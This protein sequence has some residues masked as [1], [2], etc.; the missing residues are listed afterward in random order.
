ML[1]CLGVVDNHAVLLQFGTLSIDSFVKRGF[2]MKPRIIPILTWSAAVIAGNAPRSDP[3]ALLWIYLDAE[4]NTNHRQDIR[5]R[6]P[7]VIV[8]ECI[9]IPS[10]AEAS[11]SVINSCEERIYMVSHPAPTWNLI[12]LPVQGILYAPSGVLMKICLANFSKKLT[13]LLKGMLFGVGTNI[14]G[15]FSRLQQAAAIFARD[16]EEEDKSVQT[17]WQLYSTRKRAARKLDGQTQKRRPTMILRQINIGGKRPNLRTVHWN[18]SGD[19]GHPCQISTNVGM[20]FGEHWQGQTPHQTD[21]TKCTTHQIHPIRRWARVRELGKAYFNK[22]L[23]MNVVEP[24]R[25]ASASL[26]VFVQKMDSS[27]LTCIDYRTLNNLIIND[28]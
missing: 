16:M 23:R 1:V 26:I 25:S 11:A 9:W 14:L 6:T 24:A 12:V 27:L 8:K 10:N 4:T 19:I 22:M 13:T 20:T 2:L 15:P 28:E 17:L 5:E 21:C 7:L 3:L 18:R